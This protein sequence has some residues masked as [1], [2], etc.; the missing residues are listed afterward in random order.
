MALKRPPKG[1]K[2]SEFREAGF[3]ASVK[4]KLVSGEEKEENR[5]KEGSQAQLART[6]A[7]REARAP[8]LDLVNGT[9]A[10]SGGVWGQHGV[11]W[12]KKSTSRLLVQKWVLKVGE[13][14]K[15]VFTAF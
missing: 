8:F 1:L 15:R 10:R 3:G 5:P 13:A 6:E 14:E 7:G 2:T 12:V 11:I 9:R 4:R